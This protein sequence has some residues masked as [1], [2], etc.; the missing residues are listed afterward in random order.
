MNFFEKLFKSKPEKV[1]EYFDFKIVDTVS[2]E[3]DIVYKTDGEMGT[4]YPYVRLNF[5]TG[6]YTIVFGL[7][8]YIEYGGGTD[9]VWQLDMFTKE[10]GALLVLDMSIEDLGTIMSNLKKLIITLKRNNFKVEKIVFGTSYEPLSG[11]DFNYMVEI[12]NS[13]KQNSISPTPFEEWR[14]KHHESA[15]LLSFYADHIKSTNFATEKSEQIYLKYKKEMEEK[16][17]AKKRSDLFV[18]GLGKYFGKEKIT[19]SEQNSVALDVSE[20]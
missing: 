6:K 15:S 10:F 2:D 13:Y 20:L 3:L 14:L 1:T 17:Y 5:K 19:V 9:G 12:Y 4:R 7:E 18:L 11:K 8:S 16:G